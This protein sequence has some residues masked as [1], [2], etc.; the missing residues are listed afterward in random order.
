MERGVQIYKI[1]IHAYMLQ[2]Q[3]QNR[4]YRFNVFSLSC[5]F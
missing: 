3:W 5:S 1:I 4:D 2:K